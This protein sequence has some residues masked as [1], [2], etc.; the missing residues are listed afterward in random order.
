MSNKSNDPAIENFKNI[1]RN[2]FSY[3]LTEYGFQEE[4][5]TLREFENEF[6]I[7]FVRPDLT[8]VIEGIHYGSAATV[9]LY[10]SKKRKTFPR[11]LNPDFQPFPSKRI[12]RKMTSQEEEIKEESQLLLLYGTDL[13]KGDFSSFERAL[14]KTQIFW[15]K[16]KS[17]R[18]FGV[19]EQE[20]VEAYRNQDWTKVVEALEPYEEKISKKMGKKLNIARENLRLKDKKD[21][22]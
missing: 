6:Q 10:D 4:D 1:C 21:E 20:A 9:Y 5:A 2:E 17:R 8:V 15:A 7:R 3:L 16:Y 13:L 22:E 18:Q 11:L 14:E 19:A 12:K